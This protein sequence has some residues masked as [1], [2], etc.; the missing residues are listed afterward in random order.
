MFPQNNHIA[1]LII[2][3]RKIYA[4]SSLQL[5][6]LVAPLSLNLPKNMRKANLFCYIEIFL[7]GQK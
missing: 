3:G 4:I 7:Q 2:E 1:N 6:D 5:R